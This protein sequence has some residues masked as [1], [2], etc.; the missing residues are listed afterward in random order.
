MHSL[1]AGCGSGTATL[2]LREA[3]L[4]RGLSPGLMRGFDL[5]PKMLERFSGNLLAHEIEGVDLFQADILHLEE[6]PDGWNNFDLI[7]SAAMLEYLPRERMVEALSGLRSLLKE[8][9]SLLLFI[10]RQNWLMSLLVGKWWSAELYGA[11]E[12]E[13][14]FRLAGFTTVT[15]TKFPFPYKHLSLWGHIIEAK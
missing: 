7:V 15:F 5:T 6:L 3:L 10:T 1:D 11:A 12:L 13:Q 4:S 14:Y 2:A 9:G 8:S